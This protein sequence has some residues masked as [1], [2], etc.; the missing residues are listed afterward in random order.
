[1]ALIN[2]RSEILGQIQQ[3][4]ANL[5]NI[6]FFKPFMNVEDSMSIS[7]I[8]T[9]LLSLLNNFPPRHFNIQL[10][11]MESF[12][13]DVKLNVRAYA[14]IFLR[15]LKMMGHNLPTTVM[16][17]METNPSILGWTIQDACKEHL[18]EECGKE[19]SV[20]YITLSESEELKLQTD[21]L[22]KFQ[23]CHDMD[24]SILSNTT[25]L[26]PL[27]L[28]FDPGKSDMERVKQW[29]L[30]GI[31]AIC[32][33]TPSNLKLSIDAF[34]IKSTIY[35]ESKSINHTIA[36]FVVQR[37]VLKSES[38]LTKFL[39]SC[40]SAI[41]P[42]VY[43]NFYSQSANRKYQVLLEHQPLSALLQVLS[44]N[45]FYGIVFKYK[46][47]VSGETIEGTVKLYM[48]AF[49]SLNLNLVDLYPGVRFVWGPSHLTAF[50]GQGMMK[51]L[52]FNKRFRT[53]S[54]FKMTSHYDQLAKLD[55]NFESKT[56]E[57]NNIVDVYYVLK[58][59]NNEIL[60]SYLA[61]INSLESMKSIEMI[62]QDQSRYIIKILPEKVVKQKRKYKPSKTNELP[63]KKK[64]V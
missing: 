61:K 22:I 48:L 10:L 37:D 7:N 19:I 16:I 15:Y 38:V 17:E 39:K 60:Q 21:D 56:I 45:I 40:Y 42:V 44:L 24:L 55:I 43:L 25:E 23:H 13:N 27:N 59:T 12:I 9:E 57:S 53:I 41:D 26:N 64:K 20:S 18:S 29:H 28:Y 6:L 47:P 58:G 30:P 32:G 14:I 54:I 3:D 50:I 36:K 4:F 46:D 33:G 8:K 1:L 31:D 11:G 2:L 49:G 5:E 62:T 52:F 51:S 63:P 34:Q 35:L